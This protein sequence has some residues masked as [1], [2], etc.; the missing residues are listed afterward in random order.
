MIFIFNKLFPTSFKSNY[1]DNF[2][3]LLLHVSVYVC[4]HVYISMQFGNFF[5]Q[6]LCGGL[7]MGV[8]SAEIKMFKIMESMY[9]YEKQ[10]AAGDRKF[11]T[12]TLKNK[13][14][15][16]EFYCQYE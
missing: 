2:F 6:S 3:L 13:S 9:N 15:S 16:L 8:L 1:A 14:K 5:L 10:D 12:T 4:V 7:W 11:N